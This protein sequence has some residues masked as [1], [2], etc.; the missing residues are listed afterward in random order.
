[1]Q[2]ANSNNFDQNIKKILLITLFLSALICFI[3]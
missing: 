2:Q 3:V 1:M